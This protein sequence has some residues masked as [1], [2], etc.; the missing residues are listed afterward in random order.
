MSVLRLRSKRTGRSGTLRLGDQNMGIPPVLDLLVESFPSP[1]ETAAAEGKDL[2]A[3]PLAA[4]VFKTL[5]DPYVGKLNFFRVFTGKIKGDSTVYNANKEKEEKISQILIM[6][7]KNQDTVAELNPGDIGAVAKLTETSTGD[8][9]TTKAN[10]VILEGIEFPEP[11]LSLAIEPRSKGDEDKLGSAINRLMEEDPSLRWSKDTDTKQTLLT[12]MG[13]THLGIVLER[14]Q[15]KFGVEV[16]T[17][18]PKVPYRET[19]RAP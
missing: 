5:A 18:E 6:R 19:I 14:L 3:E 16:N 9:F 8:T 13:E 7:G 12:G 17:K 10:P 11:R 15:R 4:L 1:A 2:A